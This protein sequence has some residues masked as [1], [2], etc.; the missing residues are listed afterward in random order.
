MTRNVTL[1]CGF[2]LFILLPS[3]RRPLFGQDAGVAN[4]PCLVCRGD[5]QAKMMK[6][7]HEGRWVH[8]CNGMCHEK[9]LKD[10]D[11]FFTAL[12]SQ[13]AL[14]GEEQILPERMHFGW[15]YFGVYILAGLLCGAL[16]SF[17]AVSRGKAGL[18]WLLAGILV[19]VL[20][21]LYIALVVKS[22]VLQNAPDGMGKIPSTPNPVIC[23]ECQNENHP[24][25]S[26]CLQCGHALIPTAEGE[27]KAVGKPSPG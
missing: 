24:S 18:P 12:Q 7:Q 23:P 19:N 11:T 10:P 3:D 13:S 16:C 22:P 15:F 2:L 9:W 17:M 5:D 25:A 14:F 1:V 6:L 20:A 27:I 21:V 4:R 26:N 8:V